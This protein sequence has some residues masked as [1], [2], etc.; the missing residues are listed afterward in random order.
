MFGIDMKKSIIHVI[1]GPYEYF[2]DTGEQLIKLLQHTGARR[3]HVEYVGECDAHSPW[4]LFDPR[5]QDKNAW[6]VV[7]V[8]HVH[9]PK[10][11]AQRC[12]A[13]YTEHELPEAPCHT[14]PWECC[15]AWHFSPAL[16]RP[17]RL[18]R[19]IER[20]THRDFSVFNDPLL[21]YTY[22]RA[23]A[24]C[25]ASNSV[26]ATKTPQ[27]FVPLT[28]HFQIVKPMKTVNHDIG[29]YAGFESRAIDVIMP[30]NTPYRRRIANQL[31]GR[32]LTVVDSPWNHELQR[33]PA[34]KQA[35]MFLNVHAKPISTQLRIAL[36]ST[37][38]KASL[39]LDPN[40]PLCAF[41]THRMSKLLQICPIP[42]LCE[43]S[44]DEFYFKHLH[45]EFPMYP[46]P[47]LLDQ[48]NRLCR[49]PG[50]WTSLMH[51][52]VALKPLLALKIDT[53]ACFELTNREHVE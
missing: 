11:C 34:I 13:L 3:V 29:Y 48:V 2:R 39:K 10:R 37:T 4:G 18:E 14:S 15:M 47:D 42:F 44:I 28:W 26:D 36:T 52:C 20:L 7:S 21:M 17:R 32:G 53:L 33:S 38:K 46:M 6:F 31:R 23:F 24:P 19:L 5:W 8:A 22:E 41:E 45:P 43:T 30:L 35:K 9:V 50:V 12:V 16:C 27:C 51:V 1:L 49:D 25:S 40:T